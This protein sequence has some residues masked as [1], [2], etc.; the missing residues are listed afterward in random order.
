MKNIVMKNFFLFLSITLFFASC[1]QSKHDGFEKT[2]NGLYYQFIRKSGSASK[3]ALK[4]VLFCR[5]SLS[6]L[7]EQGDSLIFDSKRSPDYPKDIKF[8]QVDSNS[9]KGDIMEGLALMAKG[10]SAE[11]IVN[12]DSFFLKA[13]K[14]DKLPS[15][16]KPGS[17]LIFRIGLVD[18]KSE[19][20]TTQI[21][22]ELQAKYEA[23]RQDKLK[24]AAEE[25]PELIKGYLEKNNHKIK[26][27]GSGLYFISTHA[28]NGPKP[29]IGQKVTVHY[30]GYF[31][32]GRKFDSS[33]DR[34]QPITF[35][36]G[37]D[38]VIAGW[39]EGIAM[40]QLGSAAT[41]VI[42]SV[43]AYGSNGN[44]VIP[45]YSPLVFD[46]QLIKIE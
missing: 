16:I 36:L 28:G 18:I 39:D 3:P 43:L 26:P 33:L 42:P 17:E 13:N 5:M 14:L 15:W 45:P 10:D 27:T 12:A 38:S 4:D 19:N 2:S 23:E 24:A 11:F 31:I 22:S 41:I 7:K 30:T 21:I 32:N 40:M 25:E 37:Q 8:L 35:P 1:R 6:V 46:V 44:E 9:F 20:E 34:N 29:R